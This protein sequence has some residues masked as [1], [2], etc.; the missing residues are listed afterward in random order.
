MK[1]L[2]VLTAIAITPLVAAAQHAGSGSPAPST[3][4][5]REASQFDF[6]IGQWQLEV[7]PAVS[8]LAAKIHGVPKLVGTWK[9]WRAFDGFGIEDELR[10]VDQSGNP[11]TLAHALRVYDAAARRWTSS[12]LDVYRA[13]V[14]ASTA[15]WG[16]NQMTATSRGTDK[17]GKPFVAR[18][19]F[20]DI[21]PASFRFVQERSTDD[22]R[23]WTETLRIQ[24]KRTAPTAAR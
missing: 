16:S 12:T 14:V 24:A 10:I 3:V 17:D 18:T 20:T 19:R 23:T 7:R 11:K 22:G 15:E 2:L 9:A 4:A 6:L 13:T 8:S 5:P 1:S 21:T